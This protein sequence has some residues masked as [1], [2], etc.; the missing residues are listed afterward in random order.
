MN[1][2]AKRFIQIGFLLLLQAAALFIAAGRL[3]WVAGWAYM[4]IYVGFIGI[5][6]LIMLPHGAASSK[7]PA[8]GTGC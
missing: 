3:S 4:G 5:N 2:V 8:A 7:T 6:A 1:A